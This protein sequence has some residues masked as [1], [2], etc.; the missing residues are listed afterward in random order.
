M[1]KP[2]IEVVMIV[3]NE[4]A[5]LGRALE[6]VKDADF[7]TV[8]DTGSDDNGATVA[9]AKKYTSKVYEDYKWQDDF[10]S[11]RNWAKSKAEGMWCLSLDA[12]EFVH[13]FQEVR[14]AVELAQSNA[15]RCTLIA[16]NRSDLE[17]TFARLFKN[18][19]E[20]EWVEPI[21]NHLNISGE[22]ERV[23][24][25]KITFGWSPAHEKDPNR[26]LRILE[27]AV[28]QDPTP[29][30]LYYLGREY[31]YKQKYEKCVLALGR[32]VRTDL[33]P[34]QRA[35]GF[36]IMSMAFSKLGQDDDARDACLQCLAINSDFKE[37]IEWM[38]NISTPQNAPQWRRM[39]RTAN[40]RDLLIMR[41]PAI[42]DKIDI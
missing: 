5:L 41:S 21:H 2:T 31:W 11:A 20:I 12:D 16:E 39:A 40:N 38:A 27:K 34:A 8:V 4:S 19:P 18:V 23:G 13:D 35:D 28:K 32:Q 36:L 37:A 1:N 6:S 30:R 25:V 29:R 7:I 33:W 17:F 42:S 3:K 22:G 10:A 9:I 26:A 24:D 14:R 15:I